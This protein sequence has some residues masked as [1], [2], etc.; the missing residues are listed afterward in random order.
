MPIPNSWT[1]TALGPGT[2]HLADPAGLCW[3]SALGGW[4]WGPRSSC[5]SP[6][7]PGMSPPHLHQPRRTRCRCTECTAHD[8][9]LAK[10]VV[11]LR[12]MITPP[13]PTQAQ[14]EGPRAG[15]GLLPPPA[16]A[17]DARLQQ[18]PSCMPHS[19]S[20]LTAWLQSACPHRHWK[21][22][23]GVCPYTAVL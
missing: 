6:A 23:L 22:C 16:A 4:F 19:C 21:S 7:P 20:L 18:K 9:D 13:D 12:A 11:E 8:G 10:A 14:S 1:R 3:V 2:C 15:T 5:Q 17:G